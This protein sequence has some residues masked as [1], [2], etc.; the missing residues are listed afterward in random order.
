[1]LTN[2]RDSPAFQ[3]FPQDHTKGRRFGKIFW[4]FSYHVHGGILRRERNSKQEC[5]SWLA[6]CES[7]VRLVL[8]SYFI[9]APTDQNFFKLQDQ[10]SH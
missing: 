10:R 3:I 9:D 5:F 1:M 8:L 7:Q 4:S 6:Y 2:C